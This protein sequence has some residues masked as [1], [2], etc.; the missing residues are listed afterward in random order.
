MVQSSAI[1]PIPPF[2]I[3]NP[4]NHLGGK[5]EKSQFRVALSL[6][7]FLLGWACPGCHQG[8]ADVVYAVIGKVLLSSGISAAYPWLNLW[9]SSNS[10]FSKS[11]Q[12]WEKS[13][14]PFAHAPAS[15]NLAIRHILETESDVEKRH[16]GSSSLAHWYTR[17][18]PGPKT[19]LVSFWDPS[20]YQFRSSTYLK[21]SADN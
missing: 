15:H 4:Q 5:I 18:S 20:T 13:D 11:H 16:V 6:P 2:Y 19:Y 21:K 3:P 7:S 17:G 9:A 12:L 10:S 14:T 8:A 1:S